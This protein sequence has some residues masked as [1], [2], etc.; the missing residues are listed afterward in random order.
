MLSPNPR[1]L[2]TILNN[3]SDTARKY[4]MKINT[5]KT[6]VITFTKLNLTPTFTIRVG[7]EVL[8]KVDSFKYLGSILTTDGRCTREIRS[9]LSQA[10]QTYFKKV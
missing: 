4:G 10:K 8:E 6:K 3:E 7:N 9:R 2:Q 5:T 1:G